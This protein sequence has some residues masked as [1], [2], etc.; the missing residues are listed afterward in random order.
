[1]ICQVLNIRITWWSMPFSFFQA[2]FSHQLF[3][4]ITIFPTMSQPKNP[5]P[6]HPADA[7]PMSLV[8]LRG[9]PAADAF[10]GD[11]LTAGDLPL[12]IYI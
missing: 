5:P 2:T 3:G 10:G 4:L 1:M 12:S 7:V 6:R 8:D 9:H 11:Q